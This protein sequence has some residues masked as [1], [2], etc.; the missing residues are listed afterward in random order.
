MSISKI[1]G[2]STVN[3]LEQLG[4]YNI[5]DSDKIMVFEHKEN[6]SYIIIKQVNKNYVLNFKNNNNEKFLKSDWYLGNSDG[7]CCTD[8]FTIMEK[9]EF[10]KFCKC[11]QQ[12]VIDDEE[13]K[14][15]LE[16][17]WNNTKQETLLT[18]FRKFEHIDKLI[19]SH[20]SFIITEDEPNI[21]IIHDGNYNMNIQVQVEENDIQVYVFDEKGEELGSETLGNINS[22]DNTIFN[23][24][25][26]YE[27]TY[28]D[29][30]KER[31]DKAM[32]QDKQTEIKIK[33]EEKQNN[34]PKGFENVRI[35]K[36]D[37]G[38]HLLD[39]IKSSGIE[40]MKI[41]SENGFYVQM[42]LPTCFYIG[43]NDGNS[44]VVY[45]K[46][47]NEK[48]AI[49]SSSLYRSD[50]VEWLLTDDINNLIGVDTGF[51]S[52]INVIKT[53]ISKTI[54]TDKKY[55]VFNDTQKQIKDICDSLSDLLVYKN[56][57]YGNSALEPKNIFY[58]G[59]A[60]T[61]ILIR[62]DDKLGR[63]INNTNG[64]R[65]NDVCDIIGYLVLYLVFK[66]VSKVDIEK[67][68]D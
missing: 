43:D 10:K 38:K 24:A 15:L 13:D 27:R 64:I 29:I 47:L 39:I 56:Q 65:V 12:E 55:Y 61:S 45:T 63:I 40:I 28:Q 59:N 62:L 49:Y 16:K 26:F 19:K 37:D 7:V 17:T 42:D 1:L 9:P 18:K 58:K 57:K 4:Y 31:F 48:T 2:N 66:N 23:F 5:E 67:L 60:E 54:D 22:L 51:K 34:M 46:K 20:T 8:I 68:K 41:L 52:F 53:K 30:R 35:H 36:G 3:E 6:K 44:F 50:K 32:E 21:F 11:E 33:T 14:S 25:I